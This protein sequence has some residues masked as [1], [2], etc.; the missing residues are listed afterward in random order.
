MSADIRVENFEVPV[1]VLACAG[2]IREESE[3]SVSLI[4]VPSRRRNHF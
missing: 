2:L 4:T 1:Q 3:R